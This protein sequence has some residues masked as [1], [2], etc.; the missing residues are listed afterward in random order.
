M[1][2]YT[3]T[4]D[5]GE[6][7][8]LGGVRVPKSSPRVEAYGEVDELNAL[9]GLVVASLDDEE[10]SKA[11]LGIQRDLFAIGAQLADVRPEEKRPDKTTLAQGRIQELEVLID[12]YEAE[13]SPLR[14]FIL[15]GGAQAGA[16][17]HL[18]RTV[19]RRVERR[20]VA[21]NQEAR[22]SPVVLAYLN[23]LSDLLFV[24]ARV[25]NHREGKEEI[26]W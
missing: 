2:I 23:R 12:R 8:L 6:T 17:L 10:V 1:K 21:L 20:V 15:P 3:K 22:V 16:L 4:G 9:L 14:R 13:L 7:G 18:A 25:L 19:C 24:L 5:K 26:P 11:L